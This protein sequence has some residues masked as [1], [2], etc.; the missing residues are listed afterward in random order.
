M[1]NGVFEG[2]GDW[3]IVRVVVVAVEREVLEGDL[4]ELQLLRSKANQRL[5][6]QPI[7]LKESC[8]VGPVRQAYQCSGL[9]AVLGL[10]VASVASVAGVEANSVQ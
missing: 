8:T 3:R 7:D 5:R 9:G 2:P 10:R 6:E 4:A 1:Q